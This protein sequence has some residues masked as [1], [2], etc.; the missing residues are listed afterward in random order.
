[1]G[2]NIVDS[3]GDRIKG[4]EARETERRALPGLP[5]VVR[6]DGRSFSRFT[7]GMKRPFDQDLADLMVEVT[8]FLVEQTH[9]AVGYTES[10][11]RLRPV[12]FEWV[13]R[14]VAKSTIVGRFGRLTTMAGRA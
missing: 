1:M 13:G 11:F 14:L 4:Y 6:V 12:P 5:L 8:K 10:L 3:L 7:R 2:R 9:A